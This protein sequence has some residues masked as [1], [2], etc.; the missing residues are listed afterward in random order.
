MRVTNS[1]IM[2]NSLNDLALLREKYENAQALVNGRGLERPSEDPARVV[3]AI[4]L[5]AAKVRLERSQRSSSD[6]KDWLN[7][8]EDQLAAMIDDMDQMRNLAQQAGSPAFQT[9]EDRERMAR[10]IEAVRDSM[11]NK[12]NAQHRGQYLFAGGKTKT[13]PF[14]MTA[15][16]GA[17]Y[18]AASATEITREIAPGLSI[19]TNIPGSRFL[20]EDDPIGTFTQLAKE[21]RA[22][23]ISMVSARIEHIDRQANN[24]INLRAEIGVRQDML[25][26]YTAYGQDAMVNLETRITELDRKSVV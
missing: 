9:P 21:L 3:E 20:E 14:E 19:A 7:A 5:S 4:D 16:G 17:N 13:K 23:D 11:L 22:G 2:N 24:L 12:M 6:A 10:E 18:V 1:M 25:E 26:Q 15:A 8:A